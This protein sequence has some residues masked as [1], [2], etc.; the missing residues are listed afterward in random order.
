[1]EL[2]ALT[3]DVFYLPF[4]ESFLRPNL[5][6]IKGKDKGLGIDAGNSPMHRKDFFKAIENRG[7]PLPETIVLT[8]CHW[9]HSC[10]VAGFEGQVLATE[11][12]KK[13]LQAYEGQVW[14][15]KGLLERKKSKELSRYSYLFMRKEYRDKV[16]YPGR[17]D[18][19]YTGSLEMDLGEKIVNL[20]EVVTPHSEKST[21]VWIPEDQVL[22][23]GDADHPDYDGYEENY[24]G[25][26]TK[27][28][29]Q[30]L[31]KIPFQY[32]CPAHLDPMDRQEARARLEEIRGKIHEE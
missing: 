10:G 19:T 17:V 2:K 13:C 7:F 23:V 20:I 8:H 14:D 11:E 26:K 3:K 6:Y 18:N 4:N 1:M 12:S 24:E 25:R 5:F 31:E 28:F 29:L 15:K 9:D 27:L 22:I 16:I 32:Y 30:T 21:L